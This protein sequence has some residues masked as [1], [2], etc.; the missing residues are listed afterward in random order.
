MNSQPNRA[1]LEARG[2][3]KSF[4]GVVAVDDVSLS[5]YQGEVNALV[6]ENGAG[7]TTLM[8]ILA[9]VYSPD[10]G[11]ILLEGKEVIFSDT[12]QAQ[13]RG[14][15]IIHQELN[16]IPYLSVAENIF[17]GREFVTRLGFM[18][19][20]RMNRKAADLLAELQLPIAPRA[21]VANL[22]VGQQQVVEI[23]KALSS[24][25]RVII[26]DEPT[27]AI[28][29]HEVEVLF[30][31]I[32]TLKQQGVAIVY[33]TH[34]LEELFRI[35][36]RVAV[37]R[38]GKLVA[39]SPLKDVSRDDIVRMMVGRDLRNLYRKPPSTGQEEVLR[40]EHVA[41]THPDRKNDYLVHDVSLSV[42]RGEVLGVFGLMGDGRTELLEAIF[43]LHPNDSS[44]ELFVE[45]AHVSIRSPSDA[46]EAGI[47]LAPED[48]KR[49]GLIPI[50]S[51][52]ANITLASL[53]KTEQFLFLRKALEK[54]LAEKY[55]RRLNIKTPSLRQ[56]VQNLSGGNQ[57][58]VILAKWL[59]TQPK[60]LLLDEPTR[61]IDVNAKREIYRL[62]DELTRAGLGI[63]MVSSEL[64]EILAVSD[65]IIV[66]SEGRKTAE[67]S[68]A[69]ANEEKIMK[70]ALPGSV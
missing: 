22:R 2:I 20:A 11:R 34:K 27:S 10:A 62:I 48:R 51:V 69:E 56:I 70:A 58:K 4:P 64:P 49:A 21:P 45:G 5:V 19:Y 30:R 31:L 29:E 15:A 14:I 61:G 39:Y 53:K 57:Q 6:G 52:G 12:R 26:M 46:I 18:D 7:K 33:I 17:L 68:R 25:A 66:M 37:L 38:D 42:N 44:G 24:E 54:A 41:L 43:G 47:G 9:G 63:V 32:G 60:A 16:L 50:M 67:F 36:D 1:I 40:A 35:G 23:A 28:S 8:N 13:E 3:V 55:V 65:R 59:A